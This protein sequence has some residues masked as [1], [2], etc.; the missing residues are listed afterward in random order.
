MRG[1]ESEGTIM[2]TR[3]VTV[4]VLYG[5]GGIAIPI[6]IWW[7]KVA[8]IFSDD[9]SAVKSELI[10]GIVII[11]IGVGCILWGRQL[12]RP[13]PA[14]A[15]PVVL[16][17][18]VHSV[19]GIGGVKAGDKVLV[20]AGASGLESD[21]GSDQAVIRDLPNGSPACGQLTVPG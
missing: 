7:S 20:H 12:K 2:S 6:A 1:F 21:R 5:L 16:A 17:T 4:I 19:R 8:Q 10:P 14:E 15:L 11:I 3:S 18:A 9:C 13:M